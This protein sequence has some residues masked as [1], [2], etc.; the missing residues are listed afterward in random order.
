MFIDDMVFYVEMMEDNYYMLLIVGF[1]W[2]NNKK[3]YIMN[4]LVV[5]ES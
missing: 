5:F 2:G 1:V 4:N 3:I